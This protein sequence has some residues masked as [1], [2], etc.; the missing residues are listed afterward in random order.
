MGCSAVAVADP[1]PTA[2]HGD[3]SGWKSLCCCSGRGSG[4]GGWWDEVEW[5]E[6]VDKCDED[7]PEKA[8]GK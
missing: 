3:D 5:L 4:V 1:P 7:S 2:H 6:R 8:T